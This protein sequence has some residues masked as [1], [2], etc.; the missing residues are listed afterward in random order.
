MNRKES[1]TKSSSDFR[2][3][4]TSEQVSA[5]AV[6]VT[7]QTCKLVILFF[8]HLHGQCMI[9]NYFILCSVESMMDS[10]FIRPISP[11]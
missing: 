11:R 2:T 6:V 3:Q 5:K 9:G 8:R 7:V 4:N 1:E 10:T